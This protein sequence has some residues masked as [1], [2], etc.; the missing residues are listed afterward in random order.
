MNQGN[1]ISCVRHDRLHADQKME[2]NYV[3]NTK[4]LQNVHYKKNEFLG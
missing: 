1:I 4:I 3:G 2:K